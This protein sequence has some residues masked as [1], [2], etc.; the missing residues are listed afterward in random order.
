MQL[1]GYIAPLLVCNGSLQCNLRG[2]EHCRLAFSGMLITSPNCPSSISNDIHCI[3]IEYLCVS[4]GSQHYLSMNSRVVQLFGLGA[5]EKTVVAVAYSL[6]WGF[7]CCAGASLICRVIHRIL[8]YPYFFS[9]LRH[10]PS[11]KVRY[12]SLV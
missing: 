4:T 8:L 9:P 5:D 10:L 6:A 2:M 3:N 7:I 12:D 11:P 1:Q